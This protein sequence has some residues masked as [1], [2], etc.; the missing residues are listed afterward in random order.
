M[1]LLCVGALGWR[2]LHTQRLMDASR[3][4]ARQDEETSE[5][6]TEKPTMHSVYLAYEFEEEEKDAKPLDL[7][8]LQVRLIA[9]ILCE[10]RM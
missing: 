9:F 10:L 6:E 2:L 8:K 4:Q 7:S 1:L 5:K 3:S